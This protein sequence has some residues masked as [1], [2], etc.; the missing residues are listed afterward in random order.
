MHAG[1]RISAAIELLESMHQQWEAGRRIPADAALSDFYKA[2]RYMGSKDRAFVSE[3]IY[4]TLRQGGA[5]QY[6]AEQSQIRQITPR[7]IVMLALIMGLGYSPARVEEWFNGRQYAP[8]PLLREERDLAQFCAQQPLHHE[9]MPEWARFNVQDWFIPYLKREFADNFESE[10]EALNQEAPV[11]LRINTLQCAERSD[12][13]V[14]LDRA[15]FY[16]TPTPLSPLGV[17][18]QKRLPIYTL[19]CFKQGWFEMQDE[20][21]Q[22]VAALVDAKAG[23]KVIDFCAG[24]GGKTL[25][26]AAQMENKGRL[27]AWDVN[28]KR[29]NQIKKRLARAGVDNVIQHVLKH[30]ADPFLKRHIGSADWVLVDAPCSGTGTW[31]RNPDLKWRFTRNDLS[32]TVTLQSRILQ[33]AARLV[34]PQGHLVYAT[35]SLLSEENQDQV[36]R[37]LVDHPDFKVVAPP[38]LWNKGRNWE[39]DFG[40]YLQLTP[41]RHGTDG[42]FAMILKRV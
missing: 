10:M 12:L 14:K 27:L 33:N 8:K 39:Q 6:W 18:L 4:L 13:I 11:D 34:A 21:S 9:D 29:L 42:F 31:R 40:S 30:E 25:A 23:Q 5:L 19:D 15:G 3:L 24:A 32:E 2:R 22:I 16:G 38:D 41:H 36:K 20:G 35:C 28:E 7:Q 1:A 26:I 17:R 37:F